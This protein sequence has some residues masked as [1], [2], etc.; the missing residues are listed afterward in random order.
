VMAIATKM[1][2]ALPTKSPARIVAP[3]CGWRTVL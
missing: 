3:R 1:M 2:E